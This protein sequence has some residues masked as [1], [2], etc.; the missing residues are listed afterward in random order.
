MGPGHRGHDVIN[1][2]AVFEARDLSYQY[3]GNIPALKRINFSIRAGETVA[4]RGVALRPGWISL[5]V[6]AGWSAIVSTSISPATLP[7]IA[8]DSTGRV[9]V[10]ADRYMPEIP[11]YGSLNAV[12]FPEP[13]ADSIPSL[14]TMMPPVGK[15]GPVTYFIRSS[16]L[17]RSSLSHRLIR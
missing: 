5:L 17:T 3:A 10:A 8:V 4:E 1:A 13:Y 16:T 7:T 12:P 11:L 2:E 15:S 6:A 14:P 9:H